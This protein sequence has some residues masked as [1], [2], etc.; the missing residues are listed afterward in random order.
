M[1]RKREIE[2]EAVG[3]RSFRVGRSRAVEAALAH[4]R[5]GLGAGWD[6]LRPEETSTLEWFLGETWAVV[7][8]SA[9]N[10]IGFSYASSELVESLIDMGEQAQAGEVIRL[11]AARRA[12]AL[13][14]S[15]PSP[16]EAP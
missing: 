14:S 7:S 15:L 16:G 2:E 4:L 12:A 8:P 3:S 6:L 11:A 10:R 13:L 1:P 5:H 9:W